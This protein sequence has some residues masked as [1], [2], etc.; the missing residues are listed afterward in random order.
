[1]G[2]GLV[3]DDERAADWADGGGIKV[4]G[5]IAVLSGRHIRVKGGLSNEIQG[6][7][8]LQEEL[9]PQ[10]VGEGI[11]DSGKDGKEVG[12]QSGDGAFGYKLISTF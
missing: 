5:A 9:V 2:A 10:E 12:F 6:E 3:V 7:F 11:R 8:R 1:M 4:E